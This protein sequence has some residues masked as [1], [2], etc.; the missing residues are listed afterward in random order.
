[1]HCGWECGAKKKKIQTEVNRRRKKKASDWP[2]GPRATHLLNVGKDV[3]DGAGN[4]AGLILVSEHR[5][6]F[7]RR[8]LSI[9]EYGS[10]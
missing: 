9:D 4:N 1:V 8:R 7:T 2:A 6:C 10:W 3:V 5:V